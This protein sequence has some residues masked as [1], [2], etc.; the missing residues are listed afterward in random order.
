MTVQIQPTIT[1]ANETTQPMEITREVGYASSINDYLISINGLPSVKVNEILVNK[2]S[3]RALVTSIRND[4]VQALLL[5]DVKI[6]PQEAFFR[7]S[8]Q[9]SIGIGQHLIGR[10]INPLGQAIDGKGRFTDQGVS[11]GIDKSPMGIKARETIKRQFETGVA[12]VDLL[13]PIAYGQRELIIGDARSGKTSFLIDTIVNQRG[14]GIICIYACIGKPAIEIRRLADVLEVNKALDYSCIVAASSSEKAPLV[15]L[16]PA[17]AVSIAEYFE[18]RGRDVLLILDDLG[19]HA[20]FYR[21]ISLLS[22]KNPGR[23]SYP[24]DIF[25]QHAKLV[26]RAGNFK[27]EFGGRSITA[28]PVI[29]TNLD[30][31]ASYMPT[32]LMG[33]TDGHLM[34]NATRYHQGYR[35]SI[36][37]ALSV[38]RVGRQTQILAQKRLADKAKALLAEA[39]RLEAFSRLGSDISADTQKTLNM[40]R[41]IE[42]MVKQPPLT[43]IPVIVQMMLIGLVFTPFL[44]NKSVAFVENNKLK[45]IKYF[46]SLANLKLYIQQVAQFKDEE[47]FIRSLYDFIPGLEKVCSK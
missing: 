19:I 11:S 7:T 27:S 26:E 47:Q 16:T 34:F 4:E 15:Y 1:K 43:N 35:P 3:A 22:G 8:A 44:Q 45:M 33:M 12:L 46:L 2:D 31:F 9:L 23:E 5:D 32:N 14:K 6:E 40:G 17:V 13:V 41:Q 30:D 10:V 25:Y 18:A 38:S 20:K 36:D 42:A 39:N 28:L 24:G 21:E 29:E 37:V